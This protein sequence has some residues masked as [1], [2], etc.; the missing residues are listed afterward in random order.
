MGITKNKQ[1]SFRVDDD[2]ATRVDDAAER[3]ELPVADFVR[4]IFRMGFERYEMLGSLHAL[5][6]GASGAVKRQTAIERA[7]YQAAKESRG[8]H[9]T[10]RKVG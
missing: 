4:K 6:D 2:L 9:K 8:K 5:R 10:A 1:I 7:G 3:E